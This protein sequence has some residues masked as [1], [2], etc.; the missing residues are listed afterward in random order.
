MLRDRHEDALIIHTLDPAFEIVAR[1]IDDGDM[2]E[3]LQPDHACMLLIL[4]GKL[5]AKHLI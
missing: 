4:L 2:L 5:K 1:T 3:R